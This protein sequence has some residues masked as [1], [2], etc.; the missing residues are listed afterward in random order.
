[1]GFLNLF[2]RKKS[3]EKIVLD[4]GTAVYIDSEMDGSNYNGK[5]AVVTAVLPN[6]MREVAIQGTLDEGKTGDDKRVR[7][8]YHTSDLRENPMNGT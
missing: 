7:H 6:N 8:T 5:E 3:P 1:M 4:V 2:E